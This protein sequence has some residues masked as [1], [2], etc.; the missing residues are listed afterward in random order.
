MQNRSKTILFLLI[1]ILLAGIKNSS[2]ISEFEA[3]TIDLRYR[4]SK[5]IKVDDRIVILGLDQKTIDWVGRPSFAW[6]PIYGQIADVCRT[7]SASALLYDWVFSASSEKTLRELVASVSAKHSLSLPRSFIRDISFERSF[8][9]ALINACNSGLRVVLGVGLENGQP[10]ILEKSIMRSVPADCIGYFNMVTDVDGKIR[11][12]RLQT[13]SASGEVVN[14]IS[15]ALFKACFPEIVIGDDYFNEKYIGFAGKRGSFKT[16]SLADI[17]SG[18]EGVEK[19]R[20]QL[21]DKIVLTGFTEI[22]DLK[23]T[24]FGFMPGVEIH[25]N[26]INSLISNSF[27]NLANP[28]FYYFILLGFFVVQFLISLFK[29]QISLI[30]LPIGTLAYSWFAFSEFSSQIV[31]LA[32]P[33]VGFCLIFLFEIIASFYKVFREK[34]RLK[35]IFSRYVSDTVLDEILSKKDEDFLCGTRRELGILVADIRGF[36]TFSEK[37]NAHEVVAFLN[38]YFSKVTEIILN[39]D[40]VVDKFLGDGVLAFF[41]AP[42]EK[43]N[44]AENAV[45]SAIEIA[46]FS[47]TKEFKEMCGDTELKIGIAIHSGEVVFGNIGSEKKAEF[48][49]IGDAVNTTSRLESMNKE[50]KSEIICSKNMADKIDFQ[51]FSGVKFKALPK[52]EIRGKEEKLDIFSLELE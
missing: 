49:V 15:L 27:K 44:F 5:T 13:K 52:V 18:R 14:S 12:I 20:S 41:N 25:A 32:L 11:R 26:L 38:G 9:A 16:I 35:G 39:N 48:T 42:V 34:G 10:V 47:R 31:P 24:P 1:L 46:Q 36:T 37:R 30:L 6:G 28:D 29:P 4:F 51:G 33:M 40:G 21:K 45:K 50:F 43:K 23:N 17:L 22:T 19:L 3:W 7:S 8:R 2:P